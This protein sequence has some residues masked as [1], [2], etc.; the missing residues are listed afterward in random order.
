M[1]D[2]LPPESRLIDQSEVAKSSEDYDAE[3]LQL[4]TDYESRLIAAHLRTEAVRAGMID[5]DGLRLIDSSDVKLGPD[6]KLIGSRELMERLRRSKPWLF[7]STSSSSTAAVPA[8]KPVRQKTALDMT[9]EEYAFAR[10]S[11]T[12]RRY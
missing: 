1:N 6:D 9:D 4:R 5:L 10:A 8:S 11:L 7:G 12:R 2:I 3:I